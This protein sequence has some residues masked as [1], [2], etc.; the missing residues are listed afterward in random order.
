MSASRGF[1]LIFLTGACSDSSFVLDG[2]QLAEVGVLLAKDSKMGTPALRKAFGDCVGAAVE[3]LQVV[4]DEL[5]PL[6]I[7]P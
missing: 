4:A 2:F 5:F 7:L 1:L 3:V 6:M